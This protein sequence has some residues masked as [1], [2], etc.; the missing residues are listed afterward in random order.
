MRFPNDMIQRY[1]SEMISHLLTN[2]QT[3]HSTHIPNP[4]IIDDKLL[5]TMIQNYGQHLSPYPLDGY[6]VH[7][8]N[9]R[10]KVLLSEASF[11]DYGI[12]ILKAPESSNTCSN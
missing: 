7:V 4:F 11:R 6:Y 3:T 8:G 1:I 9:Q 12:Y 2:Y 10:Y 5:Y